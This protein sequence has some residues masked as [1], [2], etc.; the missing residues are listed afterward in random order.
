MDG[1][2]TLFAD[3]FSGDGMDFLGAYTFN[4]VNFMYR[5]LIQTQC[6]ISTIFN[7]DLLK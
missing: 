1:Q 2:G 3:K 4:N 6:M 5:F 7:L